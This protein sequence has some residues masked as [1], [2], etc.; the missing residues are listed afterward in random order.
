MR[1]RCSSC[2]VGQL[3]PSTQGHT[4]LLGVSGAGS[5]VCLRRASACGVSLLQGCGKVQVS[6]WLL[7]GSAFVTSASEEADPG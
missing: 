3:S 7:S 2:A 6:G 5:A 1:S 4:G